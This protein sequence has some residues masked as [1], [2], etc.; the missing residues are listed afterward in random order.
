MKIVLGVD[1]ATR[2]K[3]TADLMQALRFQSATVELVHVLDGRNESFYPVELHRPD[4]ISFYL[5]MQEDNAK[6]L[7]ASTWSDMKARDFAN[8]SSHLIHGL[9]S[10][11]LLDYCTETG[12]DVLA[13]A[14]SD[15]GSVEGVLIGSVTRKAVISA[16]CSILISK[17]PVVSGRALNVVLATDHSVYANKCIDEFI[18]WAPQGIGKMTVLTVFP[19]QLVKLM[20]SVIENFKA[21]AA[22]WVRAE[23]ERSN[24][25]VIR[26]LGS[27]G[28]E[29]RSLVESGA[30]VDT[31]ERVMKDEGAD[32]LVLGAQ[33]HGFVERLTLGSVSLDLAVRKPYSI[34][35]VRASTPP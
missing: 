25:E 13:L 7:L 2:V 34:L 9:M 32:L 11:K 3:Q 26:R 17:R 1:D 24:Q 15:K 35:V 6:E 33:G 29:R 14:S 27:L 18:R 10:N 21:D 20:T 23:L 19:E 22:G 4:A 5:K 16:R 28:I 30:V 31:L 8:V 12:A